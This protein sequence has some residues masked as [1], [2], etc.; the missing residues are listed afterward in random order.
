MVIGTS[1]IADE[2]SDAAGTDGAH[3]GKHSR[4]LIVYNHWFV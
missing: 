3:I 4:P 2:I 1:T